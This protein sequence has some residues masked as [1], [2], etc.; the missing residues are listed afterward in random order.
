ML[1]LNPDQNLILDL[2]STRYNETLR[3]MIECLKYS[4]LAQALTMVESIP[5]V[6]LS[7]A[8]SFA[9]YIQAYEII[10]SEVAMSRTS[11]NKAR[12]C[13]MIGLDS[14][15]YLVDPDLIS[16]IDPINMFY[17]IGY[18]WDISLLSKFRKPNIPPVLNDL[19]ALTFKGFL[20]TS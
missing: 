11:I 7:K 17:Q 19:F 13:K 3:P 14:S 10:I 15:E 4:P 1:N 16:S 18:I 9:T 20:N 2:D 5:M 8:Y 6:H 12:F